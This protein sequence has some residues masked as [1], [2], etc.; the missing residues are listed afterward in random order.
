MI[1]GSNWDLK[2][3]AQTVSSSKENEKTAVQDSGKRQIHT[4]SRSGA[5]HID[6]IGA[7]F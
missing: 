3:K 2:S 1:P 7:L 4:N 6:H 5:K